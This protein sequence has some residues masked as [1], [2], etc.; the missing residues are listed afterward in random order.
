MPPEADVRSI[1]S[2]R[3]L[4]AMFAEVPDP[5][6]ARAHRSTPPPM[7]PPPDVKGATRAEVRRRRV[8]ALVV[9]LGWSVALL[10][11]IGVRT[12]AG[13][14][15]L[16]ALAVPALVWCAL[17]ALTIGLAL[18]RGPLGDGR[19]ASLAAWL[20]APLFALVALASSAPGPLGPASGCFSTTLAL[21]AVPLLVATWAL[22]RAFPVRAAS[23]G[24]ALGAG[25]GLAAAALIGL[26]C[27]GA[28]GAHVALAHGLPIA[29]GAAVGALA[30]RLFGRA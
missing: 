12:D 8:L 17:A 18:G 29:I 27:A 6:A 20:A 10:A 11:W 1:A 15:S 4:E 19:G 30:G 14:G 3:E 21:A 25:T 24:A 9:A 26:H 16:A 22:G 28:S 13:A 7:P 5:L 23:R 2:D